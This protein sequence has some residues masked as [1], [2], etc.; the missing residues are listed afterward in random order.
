[1]YFLDKEYLQELPLSCLSCAG[2]GRWRAR[3]NLVRLFICSRVEDGCPVTGEGQGL[4]EV[5]GEALVESAQYSLLH[6]WLFPG[7]PQGS[8]FYQGVGI[9]SFSFNPSLQICLKFTSHS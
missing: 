3:L 7:L 6:I 5:V 9:S 1:M 8:S 2:W 4:H